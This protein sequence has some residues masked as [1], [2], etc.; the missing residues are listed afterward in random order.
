LGIPTGGRQAILDELLSF[1]HA[2]LDNFT[3]IENLFEDG[4]RAILE[5]S[6]GGTESYELV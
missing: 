5:W 2:F 3:H 1:F 6:G 4:E